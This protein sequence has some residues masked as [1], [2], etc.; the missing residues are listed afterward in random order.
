MFLILVELWLALLRK[1][2][3]RYLLTRITVLKCVVSLATRCSGV[4]KL[5]TEN[6]LLAAM[7]TECVL[8]VCVRVSRCLR[9]VTL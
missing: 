6:M 9:L 1:L 2:A 7:R 3:V 8:L 4:T 5:L